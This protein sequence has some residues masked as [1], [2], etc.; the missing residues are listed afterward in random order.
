MTYR[1]GFIPVEQVQIYVNACDVVV[2]PYRNTLTSGAIV[3]AM[4][5]ARACIAPRQGCVAALLDGDGGFLYE[6]TDPEGLANALRRA[7]ASRDELAA[8]G[9]HNAR[10][11]APW[12]WQRVATMTR[13][14]YAR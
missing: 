6:A 9:R 14:V 5:F 13:D 10:Q 11:I 7:I 2:F 3:L 4:S 8:M 1:P 12:D